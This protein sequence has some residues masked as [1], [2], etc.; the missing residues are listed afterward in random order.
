MDI[1][2]Q[3][4]KIEEAR[5]I[6]I[7]KHNILHEAHM[8]LITYLK[9]TLE[10]NIDTKRVCVDTVSDEHASLK[11]IGS[12]HGFDLYY[13]HPWACETGKTRKL[14]MNF[15][16]FGSFS[17]DDASARTYCET[18]G[19]IAGIM[20]FLEHEMLFAD[21]AKKLF[22]ARHNAMND[23]YKADDVLNS[24]ENELKAYEDDIKKS[25]ILANVKVGLKVLVYK[26]TAWRKEI[27]KTIDHV[28]AKNI[29]FAEDYGHRTSKDE[30]VN[31]LL[32][33]KWEIA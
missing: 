7:D 6:A 17:T 22:D 28:T 15:G 9:H 5:K 26:A 29:L 21:E 10:K 23:S 12:N 11:I 8:N 33:G 3:N 25:E 1:N 27:V 31:N 32:S 4:A 14:V 19:H 16:C 13:Y 18:L 30:L 2:L 24:L 20:D